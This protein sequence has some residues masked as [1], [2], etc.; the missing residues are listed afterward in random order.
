MVSCLY[1]ILLHLFLFLPKI[2]DSFS[3]GSSLFHSKYP[4]IMT[5]GNDYTDDNGPPE[6]TPF[7][8]S[9]PPSVTPPQTTSSSIPTETTQIHI[10]TP[11]PST[12]SY[13]PPV[14][15]STPNRNGVSKAVEKCKEYH[16]W[17]IRRSTFQFFIIK[18]TP[19]IE[20]EFP[21]MA[22]L[23]YG[24]ENNIQWL[25]GG[26]LISEMFVVTAAHCLKS[27]EMGPVSWVR[28]GEIDLASKESETVQMYSVVERIPHPEY[29]PASKYNDIAL[30]RLNKPVTFSEAVLPICLSTSES[31]VG[32]KL[33]ATGWGKTEVNGPRSN[34]LLRVDLEYFSN[35]VCNEAYADVS[36]KDLP[37]GVSKNKQ[38]C[39]GSRTD[40]RDTCQGDSGGPLQI[41]TDKLY[42]VGITSIGKMCGLPKTPAIYTRVLYYVPWIEQ[43]VWKDQ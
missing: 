36:K 13:N 2:S 12:Q 29:S 14:T 38:I 30:L 40:R 27:V 3:H 22:A 20:K 37:E 6:P 23:G 41:N 21:H 18:G 26:S 1:G 7:E 35:S 5:M 34:T 42:L 31:D 39:A 15:P 19:A 25:C 4:K 24:A 11:T 17:L 32:E 16:D 10:L 43:T 9:T 28:L 33:I 8:P